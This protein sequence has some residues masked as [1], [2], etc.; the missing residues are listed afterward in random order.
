MTYQERRWVAVVIFICV[1]ATS[2][3]TLL[4]YS[5]GAKGVEFTG[6]VYNVDDTSVYLSWAR[7]ATDG[8]F[9]IRNLF[10]TDPQKGQMFN[11]LFLA[12]GSLV[13]LTHAPISVIFFLVRDLGAVALLLAIY[14]LYRLLAPN[15]LQVRLT[16]FTLTALGTG[17]GWTYWPK[18]LDRNLGLLPTDVWQ[19][20]SLTFLSVNVSMLFVVSTLL[21]VLCMASLFLSEQTADRK[22]A[23]YAGLCALILGNIHSYDVLHIAVAWLIYCIVRGVCLRRFPSDAVVTGIIALV[24]ALPTTLYVLYQFKADPVFYQRAEKTYTWAPPFVYYVLGYGL[25]L[26]FGAAGAIF[27]FVRAAK[28]DSRTASASAAWLFAACWA[29]GGFV[30]AYLP[31]LSFQRKMIM[32]TDI[33]LCL[34]AALAAVQLGE[35]FLG[36]RW[37]LVVP[38]LLV[39]LS[40]PT[41][42]EW[43]Y[44]DY[45]HLIENK[46][47]TDSRPFLWPAEVDILHWISANTKQDDALIGFPDYMVYVPGYCDRAIWIGHWSETPNYEKSLRQLLWFVAADTSD[48][49]REAWLRSTHTQYFVYPNDT[50]QLPTIHNFASYPPPYLKPVYRN[51]DFTIFREALN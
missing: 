1:V 39:A 42:A 41:S 21:I 28:T 4:G 48:D 26:V 22:Y 38:V 47:E 3:V 17:L 35:R 24:I 27:V 18:W 50:S 10:T 30:A 9:F 8:H 2:L 7:Q 31:K 32:G 16:A 14:S 40:L 19:P 37:A 36:K 5:I 51:K 46:S 23:V 12:V 6:Q 29:I 43:I 34:I 20:E 33:P 25:T 44:R 13:R 49:E 11:L 45:N 15:S